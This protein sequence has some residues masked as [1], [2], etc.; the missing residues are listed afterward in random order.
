[1]YDSTM[2][3]SAPEVV[4]PDVVEDLRPR[5]H[6]SGVEHQVAQQLELGRR[7]AT[8]AS[9]A[10]HLVRLLVQFQVGE[11]VSTAHSARPKQER[12][13]TAR[14]RAVSLQAE[15]LSDSRRRPASG[16]R[17]LSSVAS[18]A[19]RKTTGVR[20][21]ASRSRRITSKPSRSGSITSSHEQVGAAS[22]RALA[23]AS[24]FRWWPR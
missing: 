21:P 23:T 12:R 10:A 3:S 8:P 18:R 24:T 22:S 13:S 2:L 11:A 5:Q 1:M 7:Q 16:P 15:R 6:P 9:A 4:L 19:V 17:I 20:T 14:I